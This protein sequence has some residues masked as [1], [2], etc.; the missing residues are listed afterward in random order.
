LAARLDLFGGMFM[1]SNGQRQPEDGQDDNHAVQIDDGI[2]VREDFEALIK[3]IYGQCVLISHPHMFLAEWHTRWTAPPYPVPFLLSVLKLSTRWGSEDGRERAIYYLGDRST[4]FSN[5]LKFYASIKYNVP[6]WTRPAFDVLVSTDWKLGDLPLLA[7]YDLSLEI[8][9]L[10][11]KTR[12]I[13]SREQRR[14]ATLPPP[15]SHHEN[16]GRHQREKCSEAWMVAWILAIGRKVVHVDPLFQ[17][18]PY[19]AADAVRGLVVPGM[20]KRCLELTVER[21]IEGDAF[22]YVHKVST[23]ALAKLSL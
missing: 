3:H 8:V 4:N 16:C 6:Q 18:Q 21:T 7:C 20:S 2:A 11:I 22:D 12:D 9:D 14:L 13:I 10:V 23:A 17:L 1:M 19:Q 15:V 5:L